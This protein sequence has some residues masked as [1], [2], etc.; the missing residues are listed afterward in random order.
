MSSLDNFGA[1]LRDS[2]RMRAEAEN[3]YTA[4]ALLQEFSEQ[5]AQAEEVDN[6]IPIAFEGSGTRGRKI[7]VHGYDLTDADDSVALA[8]FFD[9]AAAEGARL[10]Q[11]DARRSF[12]TLENFLGDA[13]SGDF[14]EGREESSAEFQL[15]SDLR[16]RGRAVSRYRLYLLT[17]LQ[18]GDR[19]KGFP[20][21]ATGTVPVDYHIWDLTRFHE[22]A[23]SSSGRE[24]L[25]ID[26]TEWSP[27]GI[28]TL[29]VPGSDETFTTYLAA[30]PAS[31]LA[32]LY[33][34]HGSRLLEG[35][36]RSYLSARGKINK[37]IRTTILGEPDR[38]LAY[39][40]GITATATEVARDE[41]GA[42]TSITDL[43]IVNGGQTTASLFYVNRDEK[44]KPDLSAVFAQMKL[45][46]VDAHEANEI[47]PQ[48]SRYANS[49]NRVNE[50]DF[51][52]NS[53]FHLRVEDLS[54]RTLAPTQAGVNYSTRWFYERT[55]GQYQNEISK[56]SESQARIFK[57]RNPKNQLITK[58]DAARYEVS[59]RQKPYMVSRGAQL[60]FVAFA[61]EVVAEWERSDA[62]F[63]EVYFKEL[64]AKGILFNQVR[65]AI[66]RSDWYESGYLANITTYTI[67]KLARE[68]DRQAPGSKF[69]FQRVWSNQEISD[70]TRETAL[71]IG[72]RVLAELLHPNRTVLNVTE[73]AKRE[74]CWNRIA[75]ASVTLPAPFLAELE[76]ADR[77]ASRARDAVAVQKIDDGIAAQTAVISA[78]PGLWVSLER[79]AK[80]SR[81][82]T[83][84]DFGILR[85]AITPG[86]VPSELQA[87]RLLAL[88]ATAEA[89]G[90]RFDD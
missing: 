56:L 21:S 28:P 53:A 50:A 39:N 81:I 35:N 32:E 1:E 37:G 17:D 68:I 52:A 6:L 71:Q 57:L 75:G 19:V 30:V 66:S 60:N 65:T 61:K 82:G 85:V 74:E 55:R 15:A 54:R 51:F 72:R 89:R 8:V 44:P 62:R 43:Q 14:E 76:G 34:R 26:L 2:A 90:F 23:T 77:R 59:W 49:Q 13:L 87:A 73:W 64:V 12:E 38:F 42:L 78:R 18:M 47:I 31:L 27:D 5:L 7:A 40:N 58:T 29:E 83:A 24:Q 36:V 84:A 41:S 69:D 79:F 86:K 63:N 67:A 22:V 11:T 33:G 4:V 16:K 9:G 46:V 3:E 70:W 45:V 20:S 10:T 88:K 48:I 80:E 25:V